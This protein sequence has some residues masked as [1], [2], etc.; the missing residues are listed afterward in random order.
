MNIWFTSDWHISHINIIKYCKRPFN[1]IKEMD[2]TIFNNFFKLVKRGDTVYFLGD[3]SFDLDVVNNFLSTINEEG[4]KLFFIKGNH[5]K[6]INYKCHQIIETTINNQLITM[7]H[8]P[9]LSWNKSHF[10]SWQLYGHHHNNDKMPIQGKM[11]NVGVDLWDFKPV[12]FNQVKDYMDKQ[13]NNWNFI[14]K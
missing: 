7:C 9:M 8:Y 12:N 13:P 11:M 5:D 6:I 4:I 3:L 1:S 2:D 10:N 14:Q